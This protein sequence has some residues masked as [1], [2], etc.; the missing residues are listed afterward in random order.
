MWVKL[1]SLN[2]STVQA[3]GGNSWLNIEFVY[4][5]V[6]GRLYIYQH[7]QLVDGL[8][9][10]RYDSCQIQIAVQYQ[11]QVQAHRHIGARSCQQVVVPQAYRCGA[12]QFR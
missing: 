5:F 11:R 4:Q 9:A 3:L 10:Y 6:S 1:V 7:N 8:Q 12:Y 2:N